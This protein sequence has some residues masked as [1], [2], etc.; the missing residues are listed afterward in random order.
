MKPFYRSMNT[1]R[2]AYYA[3]LVLEELGMETIVVAFW[4]GLYHGV[5]DTSVI[6]EWYVETSKKQ[7]EA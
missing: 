2:M 6:P 7:I 4:D 5:G 1:A 3:N